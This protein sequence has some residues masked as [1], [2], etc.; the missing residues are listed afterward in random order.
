M[1]PQSSQYRTQICGLPPKL[2]FSP[3]ASSSIDAA[4]IEQQLLLWKNQLREEEL[5]NDAQRDTLNLLRAIISFQQGRNETDREPSPLADDL[6]MQE[7]G[8]RIVHRISTDDNNTKDIENEHHHFDTWL[9]I[10][11]IK[12]IAQKLQDHHTVEGPN[13][14]LQKSTDASIVKHIQE[15]DLVLSNNTSWYE[16][17]IIPYNDAAHAILRIYDKDASKQHICRYL[18]YRGIRTMEQAKYFTI[19]SQKKQLLLLK[20]YYCKQ[21][22]LLSE[23]ERYYNDAF[24]K[25]DDYCTIFL[26]VESDTLPL[27][28]EHPASAADV[29]EN[30]AI[31][32]AINEYSG[33]VESHVRTV[34]MNELSKVS[35]RFL[36]ILGDNRKAIAT[37]IEYYL[38]FTDFLSSAQWRDG[39]ESAIDKHEMTM[40]TL[41]QFVTS[42]IDSLISEFIQSPSTRV[43]LVSDLQQLNS[44]L[45]SR[46]RELSSRAGVGR[47]VIEAIDLAWTHHCIAAE[48][49]KSGLNLNDAT[50]NDI[51]QFSSAVQNVLAKI[52]GDGLHAKR[53]RLLADVLGCLPSE[54]AFRFK[55]LC[56]RAAFLAYQMSMYQSQQE[57]SALTLGRCKLDLEMKETEIRL[58]SNRI[59][60]LTSMVTN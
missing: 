35:G 38:H 51:S 58:D 43:M 30:D 29:G 34:M 11:D 31:P 55:I 15:K 5:W 49:S 52:V 33:Q 8:R 7:F 16:V 3:S 21:Q 1:K 27:F 44:F 46:K 17:I 42:P 6:M 41:R 4:G 54:D 36:S 47:D 20:E 13:D 26:G 14:F 45:I 53:L 32:K 59:D 9:T 37:A 18:T 60:E 57:A 39:Q 24:E 19:P 12:K 40:S 50:L 25:L 48:S 56:R 23:L 2:A 10:H 22:H 28:P